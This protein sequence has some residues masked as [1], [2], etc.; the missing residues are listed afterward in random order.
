MLHIKA[1]L[2]TSAS[3]LNKIKFRDIGQEGHLAMEGI[4]DKVVI[5]EDETKILE[6]SNISLINID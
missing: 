2:N 5:V 1:F 4:T 3:K 6:D